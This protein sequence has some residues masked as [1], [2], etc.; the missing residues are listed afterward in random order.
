MK[1]WPMAL[2]IKVVLSFA[3]VYLIWGTTYL[4]IKIG[5]GYMPPFIMASLRYLIAGILLLV[6][7][8]ATSDAIFSKG[9]F[10]QMVL[11]AFMLTLGQGVLFWAEEY[12]PSGLTAIYI[13]TL[14][15]WYI[16]IDRKNWRNYLGSKLT[17]LSIVMGLTG[18]II[19][20]SGQLGSND[21]QPPFMKLVASVVV[22]LSCICWAAG[23]MYYKYNAGGPLFRNVGWQLVGGTIACFLIS[24]FTGEWDKFSLLTMPGSGWAIVIYLAIAGSILAFS[25]SYY[26]LT[27]RPAPVVGTYAYVNPIIAVILGYFIAGEAI[28]IKQL[29]AILIILAAAYLANK[30]KFGHS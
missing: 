12:L 2:D 18:I 11:G 27:V 5:L 4:A 13:A 3:A 22:V 16:V 7:C 24:L 9:V 10:K 8:V 25:A 26:L 14:P 15:I 17:L 20:F 6:F 19:L 1:K 23:S 21:H 28:T 30:V 29:S